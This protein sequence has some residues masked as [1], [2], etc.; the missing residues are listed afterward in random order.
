[1]LQ[2]SSA[3]GFE[4]SDKLH[5]LFCYFSFNCVILLEHISVSINKLKYPSPPQKM[6]MKNNTFYTSKWLDKIQSTFQQVEKL[7]EKW[8]SYQ[9][10]NNLL[11]SG[12]HQDEEKRHKGGP[13][14]SGRHIGDLLRKI[15]RWDG[16]KSENL[17]VV[18]SRENNVHERPCQ[19]NTIDLQ[20]K[21]FIWLL[22]GLS[23][24]TIGQQKGPITCSH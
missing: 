1:M 10:F 23:R 16:Q 15:P 19:Y 24:I 5:D 12:H 13:A 4:V 8:L 17:T 18:T 21:T 3:L 7:M 11:D 20:H 6:K 9:I 22:T 2:R 14:T